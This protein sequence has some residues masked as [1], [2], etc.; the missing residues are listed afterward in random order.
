MSVFIIV[1]V[2]EV[3]LAFLLLRVVYAYYTEDYYSRLEEVF[4]G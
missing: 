4:Y 3:V 2:R 1:K